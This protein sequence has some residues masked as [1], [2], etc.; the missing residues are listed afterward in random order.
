M[1]PVQEEHSVIIF[2]DMSPQIIRL[3]VDY[4]YHGEIRVPAEN[5]SVLLETAQAL[6]IVGLMD[7]SFLKKQ[8]YI[9]WYF[10][11]LISSKQVF[12]R[13]L[14]FDSYFVNVDL[15]KKVYLHCDDVL[16]VYFSSLSSR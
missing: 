1:S 8:T 3:I 4:T 14:N 2:D 5:I 15:L 13:K 9:K 16:T 12:K 11:N 10:M 7:V 6:K